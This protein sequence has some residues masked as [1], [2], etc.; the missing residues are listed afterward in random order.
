MANYVT[1]AELNTILWTSGETALI[2]E[3]NGIAT[4]YI[5]NFLRVTTLNTTLAAEEIQD[6]T[7]ANEYFTKELNPS[8]LSLVNWSAVVWQV[9]ITWRKMTFEYAPAN[10]DNVFNK[11]SFT[12]DYWFA[13]IPDD[14]KAVVYGIVWYLY[15]ARK[16]AWVSSFT[17]WQITVTYNDTEEIKWILWSWLT[18]YKKNTIYC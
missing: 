17:Q 1:E 4:A 11:I 7:W 18:K 9:N 3:L 10:I 12:Y 6:Y 13:T 2:E 8:N 14:I 15:N 5:N 16:T